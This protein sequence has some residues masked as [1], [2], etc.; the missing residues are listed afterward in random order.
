MTATTYIQGSTGEKGGVAVYGVHIYGNLYGCDEELL[1]NEVFLL[2]LVRD[3]ADV[4]NATVISAFYHKFGSSGG[5]SA[6]AIVAES[7][8]SI[9]TWPEHGYATVDVYT[10]GEHT[11]PMA[12]FEFIVK[13]LRASRYDVH[14][15]DRSMYKEES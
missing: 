11:K 5:V 15:S 12:A 8:I 6:V 14:V 9:H 10:C 13:K 7:H 1:S 4:A 3:A 2:Q